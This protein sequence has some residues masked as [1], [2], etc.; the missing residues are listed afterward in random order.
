MARSEEERYRMIRFGAFVG[1][2]GNVVLALI[3][4]IVGVIADSRALIA[5][6]VHSASDSATSVAV[7]IGVRAAKLPP[8]EDHPYGHGK[9][10]TITA[11][12]VS[13]ILFIVGVEIGM[14]A[15]RDFGEEVT[16]PHLIALYTVIFSII[17][18]EGMFQY[19]YRL[20][21]KY[22]SEALI[23]DAWHH[24]SDAFSSIAVFFGIGAVLFGNWMDITWLMYGDVVAGLFVALLIMRMAWKLGKDS[25]HN[26]LDHVLHEEDT[27]EMRAIV[28][29]VPGVRR[30]DEF[31]AREHG[32][33]V[34]VD[35]KIA[36]DPTITVEEGHDI[37]KN[38]KEALLTVNDVKDVFVH[39]NPYTPN[40]KGK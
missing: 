28:R 13:V 39:V 11:I 8:D 20:G 15:I 37:A 29:R 33:Y 18:K 31:L 30:I 21:K 27:E 25:I 23:T 16:V 2:F 5:D 6:A 17:V 10:E 32:Y 19:K 7:F 24:R 1:I 9:A 22:N 36:V 12:I 14:Q 4:G 3:K 40:G 35:I 26:V 38:V 34:I